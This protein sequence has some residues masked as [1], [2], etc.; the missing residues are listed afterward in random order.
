MEPSSL[1]LPVLL[2]NSYFSQIVEDISN[3]DSKEARILQMQQLLI[4]INQDLEESLSIIAQRFAP[5][6]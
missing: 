1:S 5:D 2:K 6:F 3:L 4:N